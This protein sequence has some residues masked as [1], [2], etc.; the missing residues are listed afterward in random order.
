MPQRL[1]LLVGV[2]RYPYLPEENQ[3]KNCANDARLL[4]HVL[5]ERF[6]FAEEGLTFLLDEAATR[7]GILA[8]LKR[9]LDRAQ[10][11]DS[12][13]FYY[14]GH[15]SQTPDEDG[16]EADGMD[17]TIVPHDSGRGDHPSRDIL[18]DE[19]HAWILKASA[20]TP[21]LTLIA[22]TCF[23]GGLARQGPRE[24]WI[25]PDRLPSAAGPARRSRSGAGPG[26]VEKGPSGFLP[27]SDRYT[28]L[29][30]CRSRESAKELPSAP[31]GAFTFCLCQELLRAPKDATYRDVLEPARVAVAAAGVRAQ[32]PQLE[33]ARD[34][35]LFG[36]TGIEP[37]RYLSVESREGSRVRLGG[38]ALHGVGLGSRWEIYPS[39]TRQAGG[40]EPLGAVRVTAVQGVSAEAE[41]EEE[42]GTIEPP[43]RAFEHSKGPESHRL[44]VSLETAGLATP[45]RIDLSGRLRRSRELR[46][47]EDGGPA[48]ARITATERDWTVEGGSG[49]L[50]PPV[51][52]LQPGSPAQLV[53]DLETHA[54][55]RQILA[56]T[57]GGEENPLRG[58]LQVQLLR[59]AA[60]GAIE[61][62]PA[63]KATGEIVYREGE[64]VAL[65]VVHH[66]GVPLYLH[67][68]NLG[69]GGGIRLFHPIAG[70][71]KPLVPGKTFEIGVEAG[72]RIK[73]EFSNSFVA[74][75][76]AAGGDEERIEGK[77]FL[78]VFAT[79]RET[80][81]S[82]LNQPGF[83]KASG[84]RPVRGGPGSP[85]A[86]LLA[87][88][89]RSGAPPAE[90][91]EDLWTVATLG[92]LLRR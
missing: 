30:A 91:P 43:A 83:G 23:S 65:R 16:D 13:L 56:I 9:L 70:S 60:D 12:L 11:G 41:I 3:L 66:A 20:V 76:R 37:A 89:T 71:N 35:F 4:A 1:A 50:I 84:S 62:A 74:W 10:A 36:V 48:E 28:L 26:F 39:G 21:D 81:L 14:S 72:R 58:C 5:R 40:A 22:D 59:R 6:G 18:D 49:L 29:A 90:D 67:V 51:P 69:L 34:R 15:G 17:E 77:E 46:F 85:L 31:H 73:V 24:K 32:T 19:I 57:D 86:R 92:F 47:V 27:L 80:D 53:A 75:F 25:A 55:F 82:G 87:R 54:R 63:E 68:F 7:D 2:D 45:A 88:G 38:G 61:P 52:R 33:G 8:G 42:K 44:S 79:T 64:Y 78:K